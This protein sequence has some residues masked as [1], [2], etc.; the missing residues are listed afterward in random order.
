[1][2]YKVTVQRKDGSR[3]AVPEIHRTTTPRHG[4]IVEVEIENATVRAL[5]SLVTTYPSK[6][7]G[8]A[9]ETV[10]DVGATE[11]D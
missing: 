6:S 2:P 3:I 9:V 1:M 5:V 7:P 8:T 4:E 11:M 10:D